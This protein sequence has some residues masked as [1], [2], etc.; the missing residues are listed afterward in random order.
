MN[1]WVSEKNLTG[2]HV[3]LRSL[4]MKD[5]AGLLES[6]N[7]GELWKLWYTAI[8]SEK[9]IDDYINEAERQ[10]EARLSLPFVVICQKTG[11]TLGT[12]RFCNIDSVNQRLEIGHT[13]YR[14]SAQRSPVNTETKLLLLSYAFEELEA[15]AVEF[16][17][18]WINHASRNAILRLGAKQDGVLR[19]H[20]KLADGSIRDTV[21]FSI[22]E[23]EWP[24]VKNNLL[25][26]LNQ[27]QQV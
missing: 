4:S 2:E 16:R 20:Q 3:L 15:I 8:P 21:V 23:T 1:D 13:W 6:A 27:Y 22:I 25:F 19:N 10:Q 5:K 14:K 11:K 26:K 9:T 7:D 17:T 24:T 18:H 12:T